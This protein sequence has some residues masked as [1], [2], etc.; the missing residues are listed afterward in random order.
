MNCPQKIAEFMSESVGLK[1]EAEEYFWAVAFN[2]S[3]QLIG[4]FEVSHGSA[5]ATV[6]SPREVYQKLLMLGA[7]SW[8]AVHNHP[9]GNNSP[10]SEDKIITEKMLEAGKLLDITLL[11]H[12]IIGD[13]Y[14]SFK[15]KGNM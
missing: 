7:V 13:E 6:V 15:E 10:S 2:A 1:H 11:D 9:S 3:N 4:L 5:R 8:V 12:I 14:Y